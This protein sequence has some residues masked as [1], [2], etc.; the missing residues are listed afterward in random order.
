M[1]E[2]EL[3]LK[4]YGPVLLVAGL[5]GGVGIGY[6]LFK[7][8]PAPTPAAPAVAGTP[9]TGSE[10]STSV[11]EARNR[12]SDG[13][14]DE[15]RARMEERLQAFMDQM[16]PEQRARME[17]LR[18]QARQNFSDWQ[19]LTPEERQQRMA[20][21]ATNRLRMSPEQFQRLQSRLN[22]TPEQQE[23]WR[24]RMQ[25]WRE[26]SRNRQPPR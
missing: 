11:A 7:E 2:I 6:L 17:E 21:F 1:A 20:D 18:E 23:Q 26:R 15:R 25:E 13:A 3:K 12:R 16:P 24:Q 5:L 22:V 10:P 9:A 4:H 19:N 14:P 8:K